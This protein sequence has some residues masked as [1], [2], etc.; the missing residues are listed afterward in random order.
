MFPLIGTPVHAD[1]DP[2]FLVRAEDG[3]HLQNFRIPSELDPASLPGVVWRG[4]R[5]GGVVLY[6]FFDYNCAYCRRAA[7]DIDEMSAADPELR[8]GLVNN[9]ILSLGSVQTAK[10]QQAV[11]RLYGPAVA[12]DFHKRMFAKRGLSDGVSA[13][14]VAREI[15]LDAAKVEESADSAVVADVLQRQ[16][17]HAAS[18]G[19]STTPSFIVAGVGLLGWP[20][21][22]AMQ[23]IVSNARQCDRLVCDEKR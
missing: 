10:V 3:A 18:L 9:P 8:I 4:S 20:G 19:M 5:A 12:Y 23:S 2:D 15:G 7:R 22:K 16:A 14:V 6:E 11:L 1:V 17:R 21:K 13:L